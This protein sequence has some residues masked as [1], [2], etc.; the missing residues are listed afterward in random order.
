[1]RI[2]IKS[3]STSV[4]EQ[5]KFIAGF[6]KS[7]ISVIHIL[8]SFIKEPRDLTVPGLLSYSPGASSVFLFNEMYR[9]GR[10]S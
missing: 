7:T 4:Y 6:H 3:R 9:S 5:N 2:N 10:N 1:M 8:S